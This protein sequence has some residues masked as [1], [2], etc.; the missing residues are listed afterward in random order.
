MHTQPADS[1]R[2]SLAFLYDGGFQASCKVLLTTA[3]KTGW[4]SCIIAAIAAAGARIR[5]WDV[6][7][8]GGQAGFGQGQ[9]VEGVLR[10]LGVRRGSSNR[11]GSPAAQPLPALQNSPGAHPAPT[12]SFF[13]V[14]LS[15]SYFLRRL[16]LRRSNCRRA[17]G[18]R[19]GGAG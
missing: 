9:L 4:A 16:P 18:G 15:A 13:S 10:G 5:L 17:T 8:L 14:Y 19:G 1:S 2:S 12:S 3:L 6:L 7:G 11:A